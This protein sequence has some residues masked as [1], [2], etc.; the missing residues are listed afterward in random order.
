MSKPFSFPLSV[1][2]VILLFAPAVFAQPPADDLNGKT[3]HLHVESDDFNVFYFQNG[4]V[5]F[6]RSSKYN[7]N[8]TLAG[9]DI[10]QQDFFFTSN[11]NFSA[12]DNLKWK[13]GKAGLN[14]TSEVRFTLADFQGKDT[15][16]VIVDPAGPV[17]APPILMLE[18]PRVLNVLN[19][20]PVSAPMLLWDGNKARR[21][22]ASPDYCGWFTTMLLDPG[23]VS[24]HF[25]EVNSTDTYGL[26]GFGSSAD[27]DFA[28]LFAGL[29]AA[30]GKSTWLN[31]ATNSWTPAWPNINGVCQYQVV[32]TVRDFSKDHPDFDFGNLTGERL[33][34]GMVHPTLGTNR[35][36]VSTGISLQAPLTYGDFE[37][38][39][40]TDTSNADPKLRSY[41]SCIDIPMG[42]SLDG[43]WEYDSYRDS[44]ID[45]SFFPIE[46]TAFNKHGDVL[47]ASC[48]VMPPPESTSWSSGGPVRNGNFCM[49]SHASFIYQSGQVFSFRGDDDVWVFINDKLV[50][51]LGGI[52]TPKSDSIDLDKLGLTPGKEY[53]WD[54]FYCDRQPCGSALHMK[55]SI[56]FKQQ[57][58]L[59]G[60]ELPGP[61]P[62]SVRL[63]IWKR[64][65]AQGSCASSGGAV[66]AET[67]A[68]NLTYQLVDATGKVV[69]TLAEGT[70]HGGITIATPM[71]T[72]DTSRVT[73]SILAPG[74]TYRVIAFDALNAQIKV[75]I[76]FRVPGATSGLIRRKAFTAKNPSVRA[77]N[78]LGR[79]VPVFPNRVHSPA[80]FPKDPSPR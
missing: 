70:F 58:S 64:E 43:L 3:I 14:A 9:R 1:L 10:Y 11:G 74:A 49:E 45:H 71:I 47:R 78:V 75:E 15:L 29:F 36:P 41:E 24:G 39:W 80:V 27:F 60:K 35:K 34:H 62:G 32:A 16:W 5:P 76:P 12:G 77:R 13:F 23:I 37:K 28:G 18:A 56:Y 67:K 4:G 54:F 53:K 50:I 26:T 73:T 55:T 17:T 51:D 57:R 20:W 65:D 33:T 44:P 6:I 79:R 19:P 72:I 63:E 52:H 48:Y 42:K 61:T 25:R 59:F 31:T 40:V 7:Y 38:W 8:V 46:G 69:E 21:L 68:A 30:S 2:A 66:G 22:N